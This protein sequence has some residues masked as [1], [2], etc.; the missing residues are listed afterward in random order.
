MNVITILFIHSLSKVKRRDQYSVCV[1]HLVS[2]IPINLNSANSN[3]ANDF[4]LSLTISCI[5]NFKNIGKYE[6]GT[7]QS[8][9]KDNA[10]TVFGSK[11]IGCCVY[12]E[13][14]VSIIP[15]ISLLN[16]PC[17]ILLLDRRKGQRFEPHVH[18]YVVRIQI[19]I[20]WPINNQGSGCDLFA[21]D[22]NRQLLFNCDLT[23]Q[24]QKDQSCYYDV[25]YY[26]VDIKH[27]QTITLHTS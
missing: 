20:I 9:S 2:R 26:D 24:L 14:T 5:Q 11:L 23:V 19:G 13:K 27:Y 10:I 21:L 16:Y 18:I 4:F 7:I 25:Y 6:Q 12:F 22:L 8:R 3:A 15:V 17:V 1:I